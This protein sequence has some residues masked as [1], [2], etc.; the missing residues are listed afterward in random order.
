MPIVRRDLIALFIV[1][2][3]VA[4]I[5]YFALGVGYPLMYIGVIALIGGA[6]VFAYWIY[7]QAKGS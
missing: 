6:C 4:G 3:I 7:R 1:L 5:F 2:F